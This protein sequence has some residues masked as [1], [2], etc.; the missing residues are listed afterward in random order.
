K[1]AP[2]IR[3]KRNSGCVQH[4]DSAKQMFRIDGGGNIRRIERRPANWE[5]LE[6]ENDLR[7]IAEIIVRTS[8]SLPRGWDCGWGSWCDDAGM[9]PAAVLARDPSPGRNGPVNLSTRFAGLNGKP[10]LLA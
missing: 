10:R 1:E 7:F 8:T 5:Q 3:L 2:V 9:T 6:I 4:G